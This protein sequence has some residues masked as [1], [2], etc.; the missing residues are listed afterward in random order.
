MDT[1]AERESKEIRFWE[2]SPTESPEAD[3][4]ENIL[5]KTGEAKVFL[6]R[7]HAHEHYFSSSRNILEIGSGQGWA[8][9]LVKRLYPD[10]HVTSSDISPAAIASLYKWEHI[11]RVKLDDA[12]ACRSYE[13]PFG[14]CS[15]DLIFAFRAAHHFTRHRRTMLELKRVLRPGG[16]ALYLNEPGCKNFIYPAALRRVTRKR[17][18]VPEDVLHYR[19]LAALGEGVGLDVTVCFS[20]TLTNRQPLEMIYYIVINR[21][22]FLQQILPTGVDFIIRKVDA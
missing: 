6:E 15:F 18:Q 10:A 11:W 1:L 13:I 3:S 16:I 2:M 21:L 8:S 22:P 17:P 14:D 7:L 5:N 12:V 20:P 9:C 4:I 19:E